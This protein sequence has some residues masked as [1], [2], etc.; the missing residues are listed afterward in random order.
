MVGITVLYDLG[1]NVLTIE[2]ALLEK[3]ASSQ[4]W[5]ILEELD[6]LQGCLAKS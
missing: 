1:Q 5:S 4:L 3:G 6:H 2:S